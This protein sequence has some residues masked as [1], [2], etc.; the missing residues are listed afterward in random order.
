MCQA[1]AGIL[2]SRGRRE[3]VLEVH[4]GGLDIWVEIKF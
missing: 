4:L 2:N 1:K 3:I